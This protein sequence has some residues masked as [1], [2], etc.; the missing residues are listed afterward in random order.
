MPIV[1]C[2]LQTGIYF[3]KVFLSFENV[4]QLKFKDFQG[5]NE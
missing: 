1:F 3:A 2:S 4:P 5:T